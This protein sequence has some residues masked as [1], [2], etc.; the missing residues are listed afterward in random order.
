MN[1]KKLLVSSILG[2]M[3][4][5]LISTNIL[6]VYNIPEDAIFGLTSHSGVL[7][8]DPDVIYGTDYSVTEGSGTANNMTIILK[9][10]NS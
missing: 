7:T 2:I 8:M 10:T 4:F 9:S 1:R 6:I 5:S 3:F